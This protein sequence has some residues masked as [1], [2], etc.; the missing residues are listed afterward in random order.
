VSAEAARDRFGQARVARLATAGADGV[1]HIVPIVFVI[2]GDTIY[3][4]VDDKPKRSR[5]LRR[6]ANITASP[7]V[8][9]LVDHYAEQWDELWWVRA[10]GRGRIIDVL[11]PE[12]ARARDLLVER[13]PQYRSRRVAGPVLAIDV[14]RWSAW[15]ASG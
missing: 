3:S 10:D 1:P 6:L 2:H 15:S 14:T 7:R 12:G 8:A 4:A 9:V 13:Y 11:D 5:A